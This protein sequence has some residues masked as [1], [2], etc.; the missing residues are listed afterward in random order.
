MQYFRE[1]N[2]VF[3]EEINILNN[4]CK[5]AYSMEDAFEKVKQINL[6]DFET[7]AKEYLQLAQFIYTTYYEDIK[8]TRYTEDDGFFNYTSKLNYIYSHLFDAKIQDTYNLKTNFMNYIQ[9]DE[10]LQAK[11]VPL[12][13]RENSG[14]E[15]QLV[16]SNGTEVL[17][18]K[19]SNIYKKLVTSN[20]TAD[21]FIIPTEELIWFKKD[22]IEFAIKGEF[23]FDIMYAYTKIIAGD[24]THKT[25]A[26][27]V[28]SDLNSKADMSTDIKPDGGRDFRLFSRGVKVAEF[29]EEDVY[30]YLKAIHAVVNDSTVEVEEIDEVYIVHTDTYNDMK[31]A[32]EKLD[33]IDDK[34][35]EIEDDLAELERSASSVTETIVE[36]R[37][38]L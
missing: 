4:L 38:D 35:K 32:E 10:E 7:K 33:G 37:R 6:G 23:L 18:D 15:V 1:P 29:E 36:L 11:N 8:N 5:E 30:R 27:C 13:I 2:N 26:D 22:D 12:I 24:F 19:A 9:W 3:K 20:Y 34:L 14:H 16:N 21:K 28:L 25:F 31:E 17:T